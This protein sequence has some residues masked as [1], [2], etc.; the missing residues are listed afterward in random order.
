VF[1]PDIEV[2]GTPDGC[3]VPA[4]DGIF[5]M[6]D[7]SRRIWEGNG[8]GQEA[9]IPTGGLRYQSVQI[10][11]RTDRPRKDT[12]SLLIA[13]GMNEAAELD[14]CDAAVAA[15]AGLS[16]VRIY[17]R[18]HPNYQ[19]STRPAFGRFRA[20][21][22]VTSGT[23]SEDLD[24]ADVV[25][26]THTGLAEEALLYGVPTWQWLWPGF[27]TSPFLDVPVIPS[28]ASV[29]HLRRELL[30]FLDAPASYRPSEEVQQRVLSECFGPDPDG[31]SVR[32]ADAIEGIL[33]DRTGGGS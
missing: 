13:G 25:L 31:A 8:L 9:V 10:R 4:P 24:A 2:R 22:A 16:A 27:N 19:F 11:S 18:N 26:F 32:M 30:A 15:T 14:V 33:G 7:L 1:D 23:V 28:F 6:G 29:G 5:V 3:A 20:I 17:W 21:I 12:I